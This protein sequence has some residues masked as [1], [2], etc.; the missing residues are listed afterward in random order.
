MKQSDTGIFGEQSNVK[1]Y[2]LQKICDATTVN[3]VHI[4]E[5]I[6]SI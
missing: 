5:G 3:E 2:L 6:I 1:R 4:L